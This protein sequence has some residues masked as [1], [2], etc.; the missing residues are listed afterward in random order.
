M[1][2]FVAVIV[3][4]AGVAIA[5]PTL[6]A[7]DGV[8]PGTLYSV[9]Q[10]CGPNVLNVASLDCKT[11]SSASDITSFKGACSGSKPQCCTIPAA[12]QGVLCIDP[13]GA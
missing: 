9:P 3:A 11:P 8:C 2:S 10:C 5:Q 13:V 7:R 6:Q 4:M 1:K 12:N